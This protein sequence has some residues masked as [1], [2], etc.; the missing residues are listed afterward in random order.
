MFENNAPD[1]IFLD[2]GL[3]DISGFDVLRQIRTFSNV[4]VII[5]TV[6]GDKADVVKGLELGADDYIV[7]PFEHMELLARAQAVT[8]RTS[9]EY[10][11]NPVTIGE[12]KFGPSLSM[13]NYHGKKITLTNTEGLVLYHLMRNAGNVVS[14][15]KLAEFIWG[16]DYPG[17]DNSIRVYIRRL[18]NKL[19]VDPAHPRLIM[20]KVGVGYYIKKPE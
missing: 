1:L 16:D 19:E 6:R 5:I 14:C 20:T 15:L 2:L 7:K 10:E 18:R 17:A 9:N 4:P 8:R 11:P 13:L 3:N 12:L